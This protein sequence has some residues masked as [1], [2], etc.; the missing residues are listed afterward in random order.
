MIGTIRKGFKDLGDS[1]NVG[2][3]SSMIAMEG[4]THNFY[5]DDRERWTEG[6]WVWSD[7]WIDFG[8]NE[9]SFLQYKKEV[10]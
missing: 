3:D 1:G 2:I 9:N 6:R 7:E 10:I 5:R 4:E 8:E